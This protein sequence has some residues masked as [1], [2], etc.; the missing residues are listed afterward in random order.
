LFKSDKIEANL[1]A[2]NTIGLLIFETFPT[3]GL[4]NWGKYDIRKN[5][6]KSIAIVT[7]LLGS[8]R[9]EMLFTQVVKSG[10]VT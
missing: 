9:I 8:V 3:I 2:L 7:G 4:T 6:K 1:I 10:Q 5:K